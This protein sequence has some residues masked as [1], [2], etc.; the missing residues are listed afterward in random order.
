MQIPDQM[1]YLTLASAIGLQTWVLKEIVQIKTNI[2]TLSA[3]QDHMKTNLK[4]VIAIVAISLAPVFFLGCATGQRST[5]AAEDDLPAPNTLSALLF[6][7]VP[8]V[9]PE[10][11][12]VQIPKRETRMIIEQDANGEQRT[13]EAYVTNTVTEYRV[14]MVTNWIEVVRPEVEAVLAVGQAVAP[15]GGQYGSAAGAG[16]AVVS[17]LLGMYARKK[18]GEAQSAV[19]Q[20]TAVIKGVEQVADKLPEGNQIKRTIQDVALKM[21]VQDSLHETVKQT[22]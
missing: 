7:S 1:V 13:R 9:T 10:T 19:Q 18:N 16:L 2:A 4:T 3:N 11:N 12:V 22:T 14:Q 20:L 15:V 8:V 17:G 5:V 21:G 6:K